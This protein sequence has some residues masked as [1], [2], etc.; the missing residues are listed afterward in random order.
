MRATATPAMLASMIPWRE[1]RA[2]SLRSP[3]K[4]WRRSSD[5]SISGMEGGRPRHFSAIN[6]NV[7]V[8]IGPLRPLRRRCEQLLRRSNP[9]SFPGK[10]LERFAS[11]GMTED[12]LSSVIAA[13]SV[14]AAVAV[15]HLS[16]AAATHAHAKPDANTDA[17]ALHD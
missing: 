3:R 14:P 16:A 2:A 12:M 7:P 13:A 8:R 17:D 10:T 6:R 11:F 9:E 15:S 1:R 4:G 5:Y